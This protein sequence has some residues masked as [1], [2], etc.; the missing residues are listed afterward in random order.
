[1]D[2]ARKPGTRHVQLAGQLAAVGMV[3]LGMVS[4]DL[5]RLKP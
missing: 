4:L 1:L 5:G 3:S 2:R